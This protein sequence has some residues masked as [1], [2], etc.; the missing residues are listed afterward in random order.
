[1]FLILLLTYSIAVSAYLFRVNQLRH[2]QDDLE[3]MWQRLTSKEELSF[4]EVKALTEIAK[5]RQMQIPW[6]ERSLSALGIVAFLSMLVATSFQTINA[7]KTEVESKSLRDEI[8]SLEAQRDS[9]NRLIRDL[10]EVIVL[11]ATNDKLEK[12]E[13]GVLKQR[14][15]E[16]ERVDNSDK[17]TDSEKLRIYLALKLYDNASTLIEKSKALGDAATSENI[18]FLAEMSYLDGAR[19]RTKVLL[20]KF[21]SGLANQPID[22]QARFYV[23]NAALSADPKLYGNEI[24]ALKHISLDEANQWLEIKVNELRSEAKRRASTLETR[25]SGP[26]ESE[27]R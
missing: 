24:A 4:A 27:S 23:L 22:W 9:W 8:H 6:Y 7:V 2:G 1:M 13:Q 26:V 16:I 15:S 5:V 12:S 17:E 18:I 19:G 20:K 14:L 25:E 11:K 21:E 10:S 3:P